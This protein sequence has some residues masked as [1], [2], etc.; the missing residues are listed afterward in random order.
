VG[1]KVLMMGAYPLEPGVVRG[2]IESAT[3]TL[4]P[5]LAERD[6]VDCVTVLRFHNGDAATDYRR[7]GPK[8]E[9]FYLRSQGRLR[10]ISRSFLDVRKARRLAA[11]LN[12]DVV[13][14]QEI[15]VYGD[16]AMRCSPN[17]AVTVHGITLADASADALD[18]S[19]LSGRLRDK[20]IRNLERRV[21]RR[22]KVVISISK[23]DA[24]MLD[25]PIQGTRVSIPNAT[26]PEFFAL[27][28]SGPTEP[29]L[30]FAG[31][32]TP[33]KN[34]AGL[35]DAFARVR[36]T[37]PEAR[38]SLIGPQPDANYA[39]LVRDRVTDLGLQDSV[40]IVDQVDNERLRHEIATARAVVLFSR[41]ET[42][43]TIIAQAMAAG[44]PVLASRVG[45]VPEMVGDCETG[46]L[47]ESDDEATLADRMAKLL[48][49]QDLSLRL[50]QRGHEVALERFTAA[51]VAEM[52]VEAYRKAMA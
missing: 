50:G 13:H 4:V 20:L 6:D 14:G 8:V 12:P 51:A 26:A 40:D 32:F 37:V 52:T 49:D 18:D 46:F 48:V 19:S 41:Q 30:L 2:G 44:K 39:K 15:G 3:S 43:P 9:V 36:M 28:P 38:L 23:Y 16:I 5:A 1:I 11:Q 45:G 31:V 29:R 33:R 47:V 34:P 22:A 21:L 7:E 27:A 24:D 42:L 25:V 35:V 17:C 10:T